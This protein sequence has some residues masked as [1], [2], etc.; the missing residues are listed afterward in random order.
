MN[1]ELE[2]GSENSEIDPKES[3]MIIDVKQVSDMISVDEPD[4]AKI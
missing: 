4:L 1:L 3:P 2:F